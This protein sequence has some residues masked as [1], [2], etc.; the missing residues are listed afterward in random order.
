MKSGEIVTGSQESLEEKRSVA[1]VAAF[2]FRTLRLYAMNERKRLY[3]QDGKKKEIE[4]EDGKEAHLS[5]S[6]EG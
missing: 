2:S 6:T 1:A 3:A 5:A 4:Q